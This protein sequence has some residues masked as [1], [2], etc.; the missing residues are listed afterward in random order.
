M[1]TVLRHGSA[2]HRRR[3]LPQIA[4]GKLR[5]Q[6]FGVTRRHQAR[7]HAQSARPRCA[8][9]TTTSSTGRRS[10][11][12]RAEHSDLLLLIARTT[13]REQAKTR[14]GGLGLSGRHAARA[15]RTGISINPIRTMMNHATT[16]LFFGDLRVPAENLIG[17]EGQGFRY[18]L[19]RM[20][21]ERILDRGGVHRRCQVVHRQG[22][23]LSPRAHRVR[24]PDPAR[25]RACSSRS[26]DAGLE[27]RA[28]ELMVREAASL[29]E[30]GRIAAPR[31]YGEAARRRRLLGGRRHACRPAASALPRSSTS[32]ASS[33]KPALP[34]RADLDHL[35]L[36]IWPSTCSACLVV[37]NRR[38]RCG[39]AIAD[40]DTSNNENPDSRLRRYRQQ[41]SDRDGLSDRVT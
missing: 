37:L 9:A 10:W 20:N 41:F 27:M 33:A 21:A 17:E 8:K 28:G 4:A 35:I 12:S 30:A 15:R 11:T 31:Q 26:R 34:D 2:A 23:R 39:T 5:L 29:Y 13:P 1:G 16:E 40:L 25:T 3:W 24:P 32:S 36:P 22:D 6:A 38:A 7:T 19:Q 14:T 18:I